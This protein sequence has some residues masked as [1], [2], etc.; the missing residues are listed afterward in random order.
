MRVSAYSSPKSRSKYHVADILP[1]TSKSALLALI[2]DADE[3]GFAAMGT[4]TIIVLEAL[5]V[6]L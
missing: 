2:I 6:V 1:A 3:Q 5:H 4:R